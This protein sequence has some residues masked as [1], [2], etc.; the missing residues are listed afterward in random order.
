MTSSRR[1]AAAGAALVL[2]GWTALA[3]GVAHATTV[4]C[5]D[6]CAALY[7]LIYGPAD[8][9]AVA[10]ASGT[11]A[12]TGQPVALLAVGSTNQGEDWVLEDEGT[13]SDFYVAG[14]VSAAMNLHYGGDEVYEYDYAPDGVYT[15]YCLGVAGIAGNGAPVSLRP[16]GVNASTLWAADTADQYQRQVPLIN[17][18]DTDFSYPY[19]L[20][21]DT[22][23]ITMSTH[24]LTGGNGVIDDG[25]YWG[26]EFGALS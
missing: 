20:T 14:Y 26:T 25:Q 21:A 3:A 15:G 11:G 16:C 6:E 2:A 8:V 1:A 7:N 12:H 22:T 5:G 9:I 19:V 23:G 4:Q 17:G 24:M 10:G 18:T 13:V